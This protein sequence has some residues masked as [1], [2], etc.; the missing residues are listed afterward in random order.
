MWAKICGL[1]K[2]K[3]GFSLI[4]ISLDMIRKESGIF[5]GLKR[6]K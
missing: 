3:K 2:A 1:R 6:L 4:M 5:S